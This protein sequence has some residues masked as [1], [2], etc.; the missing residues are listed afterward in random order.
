RYVV[1]AWFQGLVYRSARGD[2]TRR[3]LIRQMVADCFPD[4][5]PTLSL[6]A[7]VVPGLAKGTAAGVGS[8]SVIVTVWP[9]S[10]SRC[11]STCPLGQAT[12]SESTRVAWP[13]PKVASFSETIRKLEPV[14]TKRSMRRPLAY[15]T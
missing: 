10:R 3:T 14:R 2:G 11:R 4:Q 9:A 6:C 8:P 1:V 5:S 15:A 12:I 13:R 7:T